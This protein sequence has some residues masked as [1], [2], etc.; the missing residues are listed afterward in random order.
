MVRVINTSTWCN[1]CFVV[2]DGVVLY[3]FDVV[4]VLLLAGFLSAPY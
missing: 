4:I 1:Y 3:C 2:V